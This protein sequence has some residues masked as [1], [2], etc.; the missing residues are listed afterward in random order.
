MA[1]LQSQVEKIARD[2]TSGPDLSDTIEIA[3][4]GGALGALLGYLKDRRGPTAK[5]FA[6][7]GAGLGVAGQY[8]LFHMLRPVIRKT[9]YGAYAVPRV[10][11]GDSPNVPYNVALSPEWQRFNPPP[12]TLGDF[13]AGQ[14]LAGNLDVNRPVCIQP[15]FPCPKG[16]EWS[17]AECRCRSIIPPPPAITSGDYYVGA[18]AG[19][20]GFRG[21]QMPFGPG[22]WPT[23]GA[24]NPMDVGWG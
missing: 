3:A 1:T 2:V 16:Q 23:N 18:V 6:V 8:M 21:G 14:G 4:L 9:V 17:D 13:Y 11:Y 5:S 24:Q 12:A 19:I 15:I 7:W 20:G 10:G 22:P